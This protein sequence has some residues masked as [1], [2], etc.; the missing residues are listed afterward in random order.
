MA[1]NTLEKVTRTVKKYYEKIQGQLDAGKIGI[2]QFLFGIDD[3]DLSAQFSLDSMVVTPHGVSFR[4]PGEQS[5]VRPF[6]PGTGKVY[7]VPRSSEKTP[8]TEED[9]DKIMAGLEATASQSAHAALRINKITMQHISA[10]AQTRWYYAL[11]TM[12]TGKFSP[13]GA[14]GHDIGLEIDYLQDAGNDITY[15]FTASGAKMD[16]ALAEMYEVYES[17]GGNP[18]DV[19]VI[20]GTDWYSKFFSDDDVRDWLISN[21]SNMLLEQSQR[22]AILNNVQGLYKVATYRPGIVSALDICQVNMGHKFTPYKGATAV[23]FFPTDEAIMF[24]VSDPRYRVFRGV[25]A[26]ENGKII[27]TVGEIVIDSF[28]ENDPPQE[29]VRSQARVAFVPANVNTIVRST[30]TFAS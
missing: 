15:D 2:D 9:Q 17:Q 10:H 20:M 18:S 4:K 11:A 26:S 24:S 3:K 22:P 30:G 23:P 21:S 13:L 7:E 25:D 14:G 8:I 12:R 29:N 1:A 6:E 5:A 27:R 28:I 19:A 16:T